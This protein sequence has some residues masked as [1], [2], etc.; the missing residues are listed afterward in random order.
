MKSEGASDDV[1]RSKV[2]EM[3]EKSIQQYGNRSKVGLEI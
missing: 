1:I 2:I 3:K